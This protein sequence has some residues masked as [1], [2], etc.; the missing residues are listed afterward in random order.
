[1]EAG[2][3]RLGRRYRAESR[4]DR[5]IDAI[6]TVPFIYLGALVSRVVSFSISFRINLNS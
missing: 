3:L 2:S 1:M 4:E 6:S 5:K